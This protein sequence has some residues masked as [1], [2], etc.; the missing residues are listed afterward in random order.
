MLVVECARAAGVSPDTVRHYVRLGLIQV[1]NLALA[2]QPPIA[3]ARKHTT[4]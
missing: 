3:R 4:Q 2:E 1:E